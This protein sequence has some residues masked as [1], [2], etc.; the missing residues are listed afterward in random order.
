MI[1]PDKQTY[2]A[3]L[4]GSVRYS[5][6]DVRTLGLCPVHDQLS[7]Y[8][9]QNNYLTMQVLV[10]FSEISFDNY[11]FDEKNGNDCLLKI[12]KGLYNRLFLLI[13][14]MLLTLLII[15]SY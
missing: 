11:I 4:N 6:K 15:T 9:E 1:G 7:E 12:G 13:N 2:T 8:L 10:W 3:L 5:G 14:K